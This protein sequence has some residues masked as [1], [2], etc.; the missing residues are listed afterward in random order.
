MIHRPLQLTN[1][2]VR[3]RSGVY[4][5]PGE[6]IPRL[7]A[8]STI[9]YALGAVLQDGLLR[10]GLVENKASISVLWPSLVSHV[11]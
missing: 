2:T 6:Q 8:E 1:E 7:F 3:Q 5:S 11:I 4:E 9:Q 10:A